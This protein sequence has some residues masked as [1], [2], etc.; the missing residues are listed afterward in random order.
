MPPTLVFCYF[1]YSFYAGQ[2]DTGELNNLINNPAKAV[3][4]F[5]E[6]GWVMGDDGALVAQ[7]VEGVDA[8]SRIAVTWRK[9]FDFISNFFPPI[10][11][12]VSL[13]EKLD[14]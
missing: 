3:E 10:T 4:Y 12:D 9:T 7:S 13:G 8:G 1:L 14:C 2:L 5:S 11:Y 6:A